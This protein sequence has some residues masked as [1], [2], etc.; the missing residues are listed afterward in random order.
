M[1]YT[2]PCGIC[3]SAKSIGVLANTLIV[4][5]N[6]QYVSNVII[7]AQ[8]DP[9]CAHGTNGTNYTIIVKIAILGISCQ[10]FVSCAE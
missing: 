1:R 5:P 3:T 2:C 7:T 9:I 4:S 10:A 8:P 6:I